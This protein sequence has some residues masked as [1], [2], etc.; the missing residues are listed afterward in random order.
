MRRSAIAWSL[1][2]RYLARDPPRSSTA[3]RLLRAARAARMPASGAR[4]G[5]TVPG[6]AHPARAV[7]PRP[8]SARRVSVPRGYSQRFNNPL[9]EPLHEPLQ[10]P[11][12]EQLHE[13]LYAILRYTVNCDL[14][15]GSCAAAASAAHPGQLPLHSIRLRAGRRRRSVRVSAYPVGGGRHRE[16]DAVVPA[17]E[18]ARGR[19]KGPGEGWVGG[20]PDR[21]RCR[22]AGLAGPA[23][24]I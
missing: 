9:Y 10:E 4:T 6:P 2:I 16:A 14:A 15:A 22:L 17:G 24:R 13:P 7:R 20:R 5:P 1:G 21:G 19:R 12:H 23:G 8:P 3:R 11:L 18:R